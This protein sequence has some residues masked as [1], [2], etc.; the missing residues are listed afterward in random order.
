MS[1]AI[2][3]LNYV[4]PS[5]EKIPDINVWLNKIL[6]GKKKYSCYAMFLLFPNDEGIIEYLSNSDNFLTLDS[7]SN[8]NCLISFIT[9]RPVD[10]TSIDASERKKEIKDYANNKFSIELAKGFKINMVD[11]PCILIFQNPQSVEHITVTLKGMKEKE[12]DDKLKAIFTV[13]QSAVG[14]QKDPVKVLVDQRNEEI[15][16]H[17]AKP[18]ISGL[19]DL[20]KTTVIAALQAVVKSI[21]G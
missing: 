9:D 19:I 5:D 20:G 17:F 15:F 3:D 4:L 12:I 13:I 8:S 10:I 16:L 7:V 18:I 11:F 14:D 6:K 1:L 21:V 2:K